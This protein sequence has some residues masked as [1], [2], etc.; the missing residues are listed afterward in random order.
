MGSAVLSESDVLPTFR[1]AHGLLSP[2]V[3]TRIADTNDLDL[4]GPLHKF[5]KTYRRHGP[6]ACVPLLS[7]PSVLPVLTRAMREI[8]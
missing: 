7:D 2:E 6:M 8:A 1:A 5:L 3:V 4:G